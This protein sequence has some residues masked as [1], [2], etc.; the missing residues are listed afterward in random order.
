MYLECSRFAYLNFLGDPASDDSEAKLEISSPLKS[1]KALIT[2]EPR[3][4]FDV[5]LNYIDSNAEFMSSNSYM[6]KCMGSA[7]GETAEGEF[8]VPVSS[9]AEDLPLRVPERLRLKLTFFLKISS[10]GEI[11]D[12]T[13]LHCI[14]FAC[15]KKMQSI[16]FKIINIRALF[17]RN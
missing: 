17:W 14:L 6:K 9:S 8:V 12:R 5:L 3:K 2:N 15:E 11:G 10:I 1:F 16:S 7:R 4:S 13:N